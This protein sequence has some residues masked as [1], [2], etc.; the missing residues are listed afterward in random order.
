MHGE[1]PDLVTAQL[2]VALDFGLAGSQPVQEGL[3]SRRMKAL[4]MQRQRQKLVD[5]VIDLA[6]QPG[7]EAPP[8]AAPAQHAGVEFIGRHIVGSGQQAGEELPGFLPGRLLFPTHRQGL[9]ERTRTLPGQGE[10]GV[11]V[12]AHQGALEQLRQA[13]VI[14]G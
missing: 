10:E 14:V 13:E 9:P 8:P 2:Q 6:A 1:Y 5:G 4:E 11:V 3:K 12:E 7:L